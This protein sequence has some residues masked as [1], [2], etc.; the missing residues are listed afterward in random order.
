MEVT[1][2]LKPSGNRLRPPGEPTESA[3]KRTL[4]LE[5]RLTEEEQTNWRGAANFG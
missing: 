2:W 1:K 4:G 5:R 3:R